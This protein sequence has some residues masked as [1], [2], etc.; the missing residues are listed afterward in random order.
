[1]GPEVRDHN[2]VV[3]NRPEAKWDGTPGD[4]IKVYEDGYPYEH[5]FDAPGKH[6]H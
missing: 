5:T 6:H 3:G 1:M 2:I 4:K